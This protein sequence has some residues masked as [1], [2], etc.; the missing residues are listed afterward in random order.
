MVSQ[1]TKSGG[2]MEGSNKKEE[3]LKAAKKL[4]GE[5]GFDAATTREISRVSGINQGLLYYYFGNKEA[6]FES[7]LD[8][9]FEE[10]EGELLATLSREGE[11]TER[12]AGVIEAYMDFLH[13]NEGFSKIIQREAAGGIHMEAIHKRLSPIF[14]RGLQMIREAYPGARRGEM[15]A[16]Q[17]LLSFY[18]MIAGYFTWRPMMGKLLGIDPEE[19]PR[20]ELRKRH[21]ARMLELVADAI[22]NERTSLSL[23]EDITQQ[24]RSGP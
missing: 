11:L 12:L 22:G 6:L 9:Y 18:S 14:E 7:V 17:V 16:D 13:R 2:R 5:A 10:L 24:E 3:I 1:A 23:K 4:F 20:L 19:K 8:R 15:A 21:M